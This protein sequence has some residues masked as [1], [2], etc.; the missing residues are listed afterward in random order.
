MKN[1]GER[2]KRLNTRIEYM[3]RDAGNYKFYGSC[4]LRGEVAAEDVAPYLIDGEFFIP[5]HVG[6]RSLTPEVRNDDDHMLHEF[7]S[8]E[9]TSGDAN[10]TTPA[11]IFVGLM[12]RNKLSNPLW[13]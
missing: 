10:V 3:Y 7:L 4:I 13:A 11:R 8:F 2:T 1:S 9:E 6:L 5:Q 12:K